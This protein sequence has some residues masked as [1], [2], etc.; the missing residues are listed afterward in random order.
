[1]E[2]LNGGIILFLRR[3][4][5]GEAGDEKSQ[6][7]AS[8]MT[9]EFAMDEKEK[10]LYPLVGSIAQPVRQALGQ[11]QEIFQALYEAGELDNLRK[12]IRLIVSGEMLTIMQEEL[13]MVMKTYNAL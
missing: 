5:L 6:K 4:G 9:A 1:M 10:S 3:R 2:G 8:I 11:S 12:V 7:F 13:E